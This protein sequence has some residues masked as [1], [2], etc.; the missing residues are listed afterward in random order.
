MS[1]LMAD[2]RRDFEIHRFPV[3]I[4]ALVPLAS[5]VLQAWLPRVLGPYAWF[6]LPLVITVYFALGRRSPIQ[7]TLMGSVLG[8]FEDALTHQAIGINGIAKT[9]VGFLA[10]SVGVRIDVD[11]Q[12]IR[13]IL[14]FLLS[15]LSSVIHIF[16]FRVLLGLSME[17]NWLIELLKAFGNSAIALVL[18]PLLD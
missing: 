2:T 14:I 18:F 6:D 10:A 5:L 16:V 9:V 8:L 1:V 15:L 4:Y 3:I 12:A 13:L 17:P 7:G 11:S